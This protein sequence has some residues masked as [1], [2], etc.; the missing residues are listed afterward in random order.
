MDPVFSTEIF[1]LIIDEVAY[2][3]TNLG[4]Q[5]RELS[6][7]A[8]VSSTFASLCQAQLFRTVTAHLVPSAQPHLQVLHRNPTLAAHVRHLK[9]VGSIAALFAPGH[10]DL[11]SP[12]PTHHDPALEVLLNLPNLDTLTIHAYVSY[13]Q[14]VHPH[15]VGFCSILDHYLSTNHL[16]SLN[17]CAVKGLPIL[18]ILSSKSLHHLHLDRCSF[19]PWR[20]ELPSVLV[21]LQDALESGFNLRTLKVVGAE[22]VDKSKEALHPL[23][24]YC[25]DLEE[26][27]AEW[28][29]VVARIDI[30]KN[31]GELSTRSV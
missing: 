22:L 14:P 13:T 24:V 10:S 20:N 29:N 2:S 25:H 6:Q 19:S 8:L 16:V 23:L 11:L 30:S 27:Q 12:S 17:I 18:R 5:K 15:T 31:P 1:K 4:Q 28:F 3:S 7:L 9:C 21:A 26:V